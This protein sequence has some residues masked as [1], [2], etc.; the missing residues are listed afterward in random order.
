LKHSSI[1]SKIIW[2]YFITNKNCQI[3]TTWNY[4]SK[5][6]FFTS[7]AAKYSQNIGINICPNGDCHVMWHFIGIENSLQTSGF[8]K[9]FIRQNYLTILVTAIPYYSFEFWPFFQRIIWKLRHTRLQ[10]SGNVR[11]GPNVELFMCRI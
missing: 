2:W 11:L 4:R 5:T 9:C 1:F 8:V 6:F 7:G 3:G 10:L